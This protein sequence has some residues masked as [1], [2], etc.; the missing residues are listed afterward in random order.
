MRVLVI[1]GTRF[2]GPYVVKE[3]REHGHEVTVFHRGQHCSSLLPQVRHFRSDRA[4]IPVMHFPPDL[5][6]EEFD[7]VIHMIPMGEAD[8]R[9]AVQAFTG[10]VL[11]LV[12]LSSGDVY[13]AYGR[14][15]GIEPGEPEAGLLTEDSALRTVLYPYR[16]KSKSTDDLNYSY[17]KILVEQQALG[18]TQLPVSVLRLPKVYGPGGNADLATIHGYQDRTEWRWT[19][20]YVEN[21]AAAVVLAAIHPHAAQR[22]YNIGEPYTPTISERLRSLPPST[23]PIA[24]ATGLDFRNDIVYDT[25]RIRTE[26]GYCEPVSYEEGIRRT[27]LW[28]RTNAV[29]SLS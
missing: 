25:T 29:S 6:N 12:V 13:Q 2:I 26:L 11:R 18:Q 7:V 15:V 22:V 14:F 4:A 27:L 1:G 20:G 5:L 23:L 10:R 3:F 24:D 8:A 17:D 21:I 16:S 9:A 19:H 28:E